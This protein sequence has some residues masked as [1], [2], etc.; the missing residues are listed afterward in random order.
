MEPTPYDDDIATLTDYVNSHPQPT[1]GT[2]MRMLGMQD[3]YRRALADMQP[4]Y[5]VLVTAAQA[6]MDEMTDCN[7]D[8]VYLTRKRRDPHCLYHSLIGAEAIEDLRTALKAYE[9][10]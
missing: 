4:K 8:M 9:A 3:G 6:I 5:A 2:L 7:C 1:N 10:C